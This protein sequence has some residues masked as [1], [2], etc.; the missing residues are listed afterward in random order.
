MAIIQKNLY[1]PG[2]DLTNLA[3]NVD[4]NRL[5]LD[6]CNITVNFGTVPATITIKQGSL[7]EVNG[8]LYAIEAADYT[9]AM[10]NATHNYI[11]FTDNPIAAF[12]SAAGKGTYNNAKLGLYDGTNL[13]RTLRWY[14]NQTSQIYNIDNSI[15]AYNIGNLETEIN[16]YC[17]LGHTTG[18]ILSRTTMT[19]PN[20]SGGQFPF[21]SAELILKKPSMIVVHISWAN[22]NNGFDGVIVDASNIEVHYNSLWL[23]P[24]AP[25]VKS[26]GN[27]NTGEQ[28]QVY[29][30]NPGTYIANGL[31]TRANS[32]GATRYIYIDINL[33]GIYG[34]TNFDSSSNYT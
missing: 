21:T 30:L 9:F 16:S 8:N 4:Y 3:Q 2:Q 27:K 7:I 18:L 26:I 23:V 1:L 31:I 32:T 28:I 10:A 13:I 20:G 34:Q 19:V 6:R 25:T 24:A 12:S 22:F 17:T 15:M 14:I 33:F 29:V 5:G 11:T